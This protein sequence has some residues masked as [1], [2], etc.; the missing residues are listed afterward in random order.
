[1]DEKLVRHSAKIRCSSPE[2]DDVVQKSALA[3]V[4]A[5]H[6]KICLQVSTNVDIITSCNTFKCLTFN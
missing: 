3:E 6:R 1:M 5:G 4:L 2:A